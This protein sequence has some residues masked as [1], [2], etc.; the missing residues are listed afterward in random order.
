MSPLAGLLPA[1]S[2]FVNLA[3]TIVPLLPEF[4]VNQT[5]PQ[6]TLALALAFNKQKIMRGKKHARKVYDYEI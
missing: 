2:Y 1:I 4:Y 6:S 5:R 3:D